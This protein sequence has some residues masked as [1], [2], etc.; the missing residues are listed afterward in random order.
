MPSLRLITIAGAPIPRGLVSRAREQL[1]CFICPAWGMTEWGIGIAA[2]PQLPSE[3]LDATDGVPV[4]GCDIRVVGPEGKRVD[5]EVEGDL[6]MKGP[7]LFVGYYERPDATGESFT[8]GWFQT[9]DRA[10]AHADGFMSLTGRS[11]DLIIR[12]GENIPV[13][14][15][16]SLLYEHPSVVD[17]AIVGVPD[18]RLGERA[19]AVVVLKEGATL[20]LSAACSFL[21]GRGLSKHFLPERLE[22]VA[23]LP[24]TP[25]GKIRKVELRASLTES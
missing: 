11:K 1:G 2:A 7:G 8:D 23:S 19:C 22:V 21:L 25:S 16:E 20:D 18:E 9:G 15:V 24:K 4:P 12:G 14:S 10:V 5:P 6:Q 3:R 13:V 17:V